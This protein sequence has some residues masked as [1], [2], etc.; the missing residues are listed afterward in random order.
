MQPLL[1]EDKAYLST[2]WLVKTLSN[3]IDFAHTKKKFNEALSGGRVLAERE[4]SLLLK[5]CWCGFLKCLNDGNE[6]LVSVIVSCFILHNITQKIVDKYVD[7][8]NLL[9][10]II[11]D[12]RARLVRYTS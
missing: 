2:D 8:G 6:Y 7:Y 10:T 11:W 4:S 1:L 9:D 3:N 12:E 5:G